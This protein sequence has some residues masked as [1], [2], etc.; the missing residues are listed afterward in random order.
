[1][2]GSVKVIRSAKCLIVSGSAEGIPSGLNDWKT[3]S[4]KFG[5]NSYNS[6]K[7]QVA[8]SKNLGAVLFFDACSYA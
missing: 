7:G 8:D 6:G 2:I 4:R 1:M 3:K 5:V